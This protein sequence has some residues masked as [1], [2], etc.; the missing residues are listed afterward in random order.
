MTIDL[1][2]GRPES[3]LLLNHLVTTFNPSSVV[4]FYFQSTDAGSELATYAADKLYLCLQIFLVGS[5]PTG[6]TASISATIYDELNSI[7]LYLSNN[8]YYF[9]TVS[10]AVN[11]GQNNLIFKD[12]Y[13]SRINFGAGVVYVQFNGY[14]ITY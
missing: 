6:G 12:F 4:P 9:N 7:N 3:S 1:K 2:Y 11:Y 10:G 5:S 14:R 13:F 8:E